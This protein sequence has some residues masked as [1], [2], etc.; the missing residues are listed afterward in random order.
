[1]TN[2]ARHAAARR[3]TLGLTITPEQVRLVIEDDGRGFD[4]A[5]TT[6]GMG[7]RNIR[8]R[9]ARLNGQIGISSQPGGGA[10]LEAMIPYQA[11]E[12]P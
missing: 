8:E 10:Q 5:Q 7:L 12:A 9:V 11:E 1:L 2:I 4:P 6:G 3:V